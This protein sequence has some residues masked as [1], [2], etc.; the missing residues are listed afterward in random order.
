[1]MDHRHG[2]TAICG[3]VKYSG[4]NFPE[5]FRGDF[6]SGNVMTSR[7][8]RN[9]PEYHGSTIK[10]IEQP[11]FLT[12]ND[13]WFRPVDIQI[14][15]DGAMYIAD[16][17][18]RIIGH[19][20]VPL[21]HPGRDRTSGRIWRVTYKTPLPPGAGAER[22]SAGKGKELSK[23]LVKLADAH[24]LEHLANRPDDMRAF[25]LLRDRGRAALSAILD[26]RSKL[27]GR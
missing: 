27:Y 18:N 26:A 17:Y 8:N 12:T 9:K 16:F 2:S 21:P 23:D 1:M 24:L 20:E 19:Y 14:G 5:E 25:S 3:L 11:D 6:Y 22:S 10:A 13:P 4:E 15:P 7:I